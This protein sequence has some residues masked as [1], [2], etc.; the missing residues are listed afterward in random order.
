[1]K[2]IDKN[3]SRFYADSV[4]VLIKNAYTVYEQ[5]AIGGAITKVDHLAVRPYFVYV[6][7]VVV[8]NQSRKYL[9]KTKM[10]R[11]CKTL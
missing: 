10:K 5:Y 2:N 3:C 9:K 7:G 8:K 6:K 1:M 4:N 11:H